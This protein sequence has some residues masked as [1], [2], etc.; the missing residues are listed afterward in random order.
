MKILLINSFYYN[1]GSTGRIVKDLYDAINANGDEAYIAYGLNRGEV[2]DDKEHIFRFERLFTKKIG[3][4]E[5][6]LFGDHGFHNSWATKMLCKWIARINPDIIHIHNLH[7]SYI[8]IEILFAFLKE[9]CKPVVMT[10]HDCWTFTGY[11]A[12][13][14]FPYCDKWKTRCCNCQYLYKYPHTYFVDRSS[15]NYI[16]KSKIFNSVDNLNI[17]TPCQWLKQEVQQSYL[18]K[19]EVRVIANG[20]DLTKFTPIYSHFKE[21]NGI[22]KMMLAV[23]SVWDESKG[24]QYLIKIADTINRTDWKLVVVGNL[25]DRRLKNQNSVVWIP[26]TNNLDEMVELYSAADVFINPTLEDTFPTVNM[27]AI[28]CGTPCVTFDTGGCGEV[29]SDATGFVITKGD[30][31]QLLKTAISCDK[32][33]MHGD[34][35]QKAK[36]KFTKE[37]S[38]Y[39]YIELYRGINTHE[40]NSL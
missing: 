20:I 5:A 33:K 39:G 36:E 19:H 34:C 29:V 37:L 26:H 3:G 31:E 24:L 14:S 16:K 18:Y 6:R 4:F 1:G 27:E 25:K 35:V 17:V 8:N 12:H 9:L 10:L 21:K 38:M 32:G 22:G 15:S 7:G 2:I 11:C 28:A 30:W 40:Y 23:A 13:Y